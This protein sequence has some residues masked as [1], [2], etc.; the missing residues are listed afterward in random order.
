MSEHTPV[1]D[2]KTRFSTR[3]A[4]Y[5]KYRPGYPPEIIDHLRQ[6][7]GLSDRWTVADVGAGTGISSAVFLAAGCHVIAVEPNPDMRAAAVELLGRDDR[8]RAVDGSAEATTLPAAAVDLVVC[9]QAFH[10]FDVPVTR[11]EFG[12]IL[13]P[14]GQV[15]LIWND[16]NRSAT[17]F[18]AEYDA[19]LRTYCIDYERVR[20]D[21]VPDDRVRAFFA[22]NA[23]REVEFPNHQTFDFDGLKG[24]LMSS[25]YAPLPGHPNHAPMLRALQDLF[26][27]HQSGGRVT[28]SYR[29]RLFYGPL[30]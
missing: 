11:R 4:D 2:A 6:S 15:V 21:Q 1:P 14:G 5:I 26:D 16:R 7:I 10:W 19:L 22:P 17:P 23:P 18:A 3:V 20:H 29:T 8:F 13:K 25:S 27:R 9:A 28:F 12:R 24:R 30:G